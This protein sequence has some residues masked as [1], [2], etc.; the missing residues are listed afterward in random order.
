MVVC[1]DIGDVAGAGAERLRKVSQ[2][3]SNYGTRVQFSVFECRLNT[4]QWIKLRAELLGIFD[5][6]RDSL[7]FYSLCESDEKRA[8]VHGLKKGL[9][10]STALIVE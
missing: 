1:Y 7:R 10:L 8:E 5:P 6:A 2:A 3:C 4:V 9:D